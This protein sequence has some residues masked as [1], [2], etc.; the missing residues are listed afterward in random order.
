MRKEQT[1]F[2]RKLRRFPLIGQ[3]YELIQDIGGTFVLF[4]RQR[5]PT[6]E[7]CPIGIVKLLSVLPGLGHIYAGFYLKGIFWLLLSLPVL[8]AF[9]YVVIDVGFINLY[10]LEAIAGIYIVLVYCCIREVDRNVDAACVNQRMISYF[11]R[12]KQITEKYKRFVL[13]NFNTTQEEQNATSE[14]TSRHESIPSDEKPE[15]KN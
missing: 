5:Y 3:I 13:G 2:L 8:G 15:K 1:P 9:I 14:E 10:T 7:S 4:F 6:A 12:E 11:E